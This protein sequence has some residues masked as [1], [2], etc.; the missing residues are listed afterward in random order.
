MR[1]QLLGRSGLRVS[2][3]CL[4]A[5]TFG[6]DWG[7]GASKEDSRK[8]FDAFAAA[9]GNFIDTAINY[10]N[11]TSESY[12]GEF[13][14]GQRERFVLATKYTL[15]RRPDDPNAGGNHRKN[16]VQ[17]VEHSLRQLGT[18]YIDLYWLHAWDFMTPVEEVMRGLD[19][20]VRAGKV[21]Y[22]GISDTPAWIVSQANTMADLRGWSRFVALQIQYSLI[23]RT[24]E[25]DLLPMATAFDLAVTAWG[26]LG[27]GALSGKYRKGTPNPAGH[28][29]SE[30]PWGEALLSDRNL[31]IAE[32]V[33]GV[34]SELDKTPSQ[35]AIAW[36]LAQHRKRGQIIPI[37]GARSESQLQ[38]NLGAFALALSDA[39]LAR[40]DE[41][42]RVAPGFPHDFLP[43]VRGAI[44]G[45]TYD[46]IDTHPHR[47]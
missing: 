44:Y 15:T 36:V 18:D 8:V 14:R 1:Y 41:A 2:Q 22:I 28:R 33:H 10:T 4:G 11:G 27:G 12:V 29:L 32:V 16:M 43:R 34:A 19:D 9:G 45:Q 7:W 26:V 13:L 35:V 21:L 31:A 42:S 20:L 6:Q 38:D 39:Q 5:M 25:R 46:L 17:S 37:V 47:S 30:G 40:L 24:P 3:A 23:E